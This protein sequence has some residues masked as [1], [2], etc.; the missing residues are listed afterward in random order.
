MVQSD[1]TD[2][3]GNLFPIFVLSLIQFFLVPIT[4]WRV[5]A[6][7]VELAYGDTEKEKASANATHFP[8]DVSSEWGKAAAARA[9][10]NKPTAGRKLRALFSGFNLYLLIFWGISLLL[11]AYISLSQ[12]E[13]V[14]HFDPY[15]VL[16]IPVGADA[17][18]IKKAYRTLSL[19]YHPDKN[20]DPEATKIFTEQ[21]TPAYKTLTDDTAREN[22]EKYGHPDGKQ[23]PKL[24]VALPSWMFGKDGTGPVV[25]ISLVA[26][27][28]LGPLFL[29]VFVITKMNKYG[30]ANGVLRETQYFFHMEKRPH[31][32]AMKA[33]R[34]LSVAMEY[35]NIPYL[36]S[37]DEPLKKLLSL[38]LKQE[39]D[40][41]D[42]KFLKRHPGVVKAH[43]LLLAQA[44]RKTHEVDP[45]LRQDLKQVMKLFPTLFNEAVNV[46]LAPVNSVGYAF[47]RPV[48]SLLDFSQC[49]TQAI[50]PSVRRDSGSVEVKGDG[51][52]DGLVSLLQLPHVDDKAASLLAKKGKVRGV[53]DLASLPGAEKRAAALSAAGLTSVQVKDVE[54][55]LA[56][57]PRAEIL[58]GTIET[59][60]ESQI[61][62]QDV[63]TCTL[64]VKISR[65]AAANLALP[66]KDGD[67]KESKETPKKLPLVGG[68][69]VRS[70]NDLPPL[71]FCEHCDREE[72]WWIAIVDHA[73]NFILSYR[74]LDKTAILAAQ[75]EPRGHVAQLKFVCPSPGTYAFSVMVL[76]DYWIGT[77]AR[78]PVKVKVGRRTQEVLDARAAKA[79]AKT[80]AGKRA[81]KLAEKKKA[82]EGD[83]GAG[84]AAKGP[85]EIAE[86]E[87][88]KDAKDTEP[89]E[90][91]SDRESDSD[92]NVSDSD[93][94]GRE[95]D[96]GYPSEETGTEESSEE[97]TDEEF[98]KRGRQRRDEQAAQLKADAAK[99][100]KEGEEKTAASSA[101]EAKPAEIQ[102][103]A[104]G[105]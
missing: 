35:I 23:A 16:N 82:S 69:T 61:V 70:A 79:A 8:G 28:I 91:S 1:P 26:F 65:G 87:I 81:A 50:S 78:Y 29:A 34:V 76:S 39:V 5:G 45:L 42:P 67:A 3:H 27:G 6:W 13:E 37:Q 33:A 77:D 86:E 64:N 31:L 51:G 85:G 54:A 10:K 100:L 60:G 14:E 74:K 52:K 59:D 40:A 88:A 12:V 71:P 63:V 90:I 7:L 75:R 57:I 56:F 38:T 30:G 92:S 19:Q 44:C 72:G 24:G 20:P 103:A 48:L 105:N 9:A 73:A 49:I 84:G 36:R 96:D 55:H 17:S 58:E 22:Y 46:F 95:R 99:L 11:V 104:S 47:A 93:D 15:K 62:E 68:A 43:A 32:G 80:P 101:K 98:L 4:L 41:K 102:P 94:E 89:E 25:L 83:A 18:Q 2:A 21:I 66:E 97:E 53:G